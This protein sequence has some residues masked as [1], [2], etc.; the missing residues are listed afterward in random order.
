MPL[1][2]DTFSLLTAAAGWY[3]LFYSRA[4]K[5]L[6]GIEVHRLNQWRVRLRRIGGAAML[7][8]GV[9]FFAGFQVVNPR[10]FVATWISV[11]ALLA[12]IVILGLID[13][14]LT[15]QVQKKLR[16]RNK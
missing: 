9:A 16:G 15:W 11:M 10:F 1:I 6:D 5:Q 8:L 7:L 13:V 4:A 12:A 3:Y 2:V 14:R